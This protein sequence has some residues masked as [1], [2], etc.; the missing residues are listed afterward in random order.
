L[1]E[2][3]LPQRRIQASRGMA[4]NTTELHLQCQIEDLYVRML[5]NTIFQLTLDSSRQSIRLA[6]LLQTE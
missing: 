5:T 6:P 1:L 4:Q 2:H 3:L